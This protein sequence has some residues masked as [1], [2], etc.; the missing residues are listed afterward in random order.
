M[1]VAHGLL[2]Q[3]ATSDVK[4]A[5]DQVSALPVYNMGGLPAKRWLDRFAR[6]LVLGRR[7]GDYTFASRVTDELVREKRLPRKRHGRAQ[8]A[9]MYFAT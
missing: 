5:Y 6:A 8:R 7:H 2:A 1:Y 9:S 4:S 3:L